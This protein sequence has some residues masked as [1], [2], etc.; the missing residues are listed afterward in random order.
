MLLLSCAICIL[1]QITLYLIYVW[2]DNLPIFSIFPLHSGW[3]ENVKCK[4]VAMGM[5]REDLFPN[6]ENDQ[7]SDF[8]YGNRCLGIC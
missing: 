5:I 8:N 3:A 7:I 4:H 6:K 1:F 2:D